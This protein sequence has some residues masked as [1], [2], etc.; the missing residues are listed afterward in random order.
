MPHSK[1]SICNSALS[2]LGKDPLVVDADGGAAQEY[3][4][5]DAAVRAYDQRLGRTLRSHPWNFATTRTALDADATA[6]AFGYAY[7]YPLPTVP[8]CARVWK[9]DPDRHGENPKFTVEGNWILTDEPAPLQLIYI[10]RI[11]DPALF[12]DDFAEAL[13]HEIAG[14]IA[15]GVLG[16][17]EAAETFRK[18][19]E[20]EMRDAKTDDSQENPQPEVDE[21]TWLRSRRFG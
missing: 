12:D 10:A 1:T 7:R 19:G 21:G 8:P 3:G 5:A 16:S 4:H 13:A 11:T 17:L 9:L 14:K 2:L 15:L 18:S 6:P 20:K